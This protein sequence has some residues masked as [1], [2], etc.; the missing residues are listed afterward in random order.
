MDSQRVGADCEGY[1]GTGWESSTVLQPDAGQLYS[2]TRTSMWVVV[3][4]RAMPAIDHQQSLVTRENGFL[5][6]LD[7][8]RTTARLVDLPI[9][10]PGER[11]CHALVL[12]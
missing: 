1:G 9:F 5:H 2:G 7:N 6:P 3:S 10:E 4:V 12:H 11:R 8:F